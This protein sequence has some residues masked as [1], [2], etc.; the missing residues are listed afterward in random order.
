MTTEAEEWSFAGRWGGGG[1]W[2]TSLLL[3][4]LIL[5]IFNE[6]IKRHLRENFDNP[7]DDCVI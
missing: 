1:K 6:I 3:K 2:K 5:Y 4:L 7:E